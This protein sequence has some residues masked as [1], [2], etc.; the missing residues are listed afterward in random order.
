MTTN[1]LVIIPCGAMSVFVKLLGGLWET[2][3]PSPLLGLS[4]TNV[5]AFGA[6]FQICDIAV[7]VVVAVVVVR[8]FVNE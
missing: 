7:V 6:S 1:K 4:E 5:F 8:L 2:T 3:G